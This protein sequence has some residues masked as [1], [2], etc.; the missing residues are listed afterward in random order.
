MGERLCFVYAI[1]HVK[2]GQPSGPIKFG[3]SDQPFARLRELQTGNP[4]QL[5]LLGM[6]SAPTRALAREWEQWIHFCHPDKAMSGEWFALD[7]WEGVEVLGY[8]VQS[9]IA[10]HFGRGEIFPGLDEPLQ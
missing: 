7:A 8:F 2:D 10:D 3:I 4:H 1:G 6:L 9:K 5:C